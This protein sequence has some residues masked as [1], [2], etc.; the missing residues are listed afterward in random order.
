MNQVSWPIPLEH[1]RRTL[2]DGRVVILY[3]LTFGAARLTI[4]APESLAMGF[5]DD[6]WSYESAAAALAAMHAWDGTGEPA[7]WS[8]HPRSGRRRPGGDPAK[9]YVWR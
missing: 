4:S 3:P 8:R 5:V 7:N 1:G 9:E 2:P 6:E